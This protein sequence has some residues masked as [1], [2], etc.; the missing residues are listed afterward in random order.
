M[1]SATI[2]LLVWQLDINQISILLQLW[3]KFV[4]C[5][6]TKQPKITPTARK[7]SSSL[8]FNQTL[9]ARRK[10]KQLIWLCSVYRSITHDNI[11]SCLCVIGR[12]SIEK[13]YIFVTLNHK[14]MWCYSTEHLIRHLQPILPWIFRK[15]A[16]LC[17]FDWTVP[18]H[19]RAPCQKACTKLLHLAVV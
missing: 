13:E 14:A 3:P 11:L 5:Q 2:V 19:T 1:K 16:G 8:H 4:L 15:C 9:K 12:R 18:S 6:L 10:C 7:F 17:G